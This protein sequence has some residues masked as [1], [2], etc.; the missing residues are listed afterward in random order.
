[1][2][3]SINFRVWTICVISRARIR[4]LSYGTPFEKVTQKN[5]ENDLLILFHFM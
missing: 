5:A 4:F 3:S 2:C 1:M